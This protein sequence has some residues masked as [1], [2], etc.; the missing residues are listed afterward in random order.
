MN[1]LLNNE[2]RVEPTMVFDAQQSEQPACEPEGPGQPTFELPVLDWEKQGGMVPA[3]VQDEADGSVLMVGWMNPEAL[4]KTL[5]TGNVTFWSR[6][7]DELWTKGETS[8]NFL[9]LQAMAKDCEGGDT[10][11]VLARP[12]GPTCSEGNRTCFDGD[13]KKILGDIGPYQRRWAMGAW[14]AEIDA[15]F[16]DRMA[17]LDDPSKE[18]YSLGLLR[19]P[20]KAVKKLGE[21]VMEFVQAAIERDV[22]ATEEELA[23]VVFA[24]ITM[25]RSRGRQISIERVMGILVARNQAKRAGSDERFNLPGKGATNGNAA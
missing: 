13:E 17:E 15:T 22:P 12:V 3:V 9:R 2:P 1:E 5:K 4:E 19:N 7:R 14:I 25:A 11:V 24:G 10:L 18:S 16:D 21:E 8:G 6:T 20:N 23:D